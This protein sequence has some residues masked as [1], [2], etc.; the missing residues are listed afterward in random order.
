MVEIT[1]PPG[2]QPPSP[3]SATSASGANP[4]STIQT[5]QPH[6]EDMP[7]GSAP[8]DTAWRRWTLLAASLSAA[9]VVVLCGWTLLSSAERSTDT[10]LSLVAEEV[11]DGEVPD[12]PPKQDSPE[13]AAAEPAPSQPKQRPPRKRHCLRLL[14]R[15]TPSRRI[16]S[17]RRNPSRISRRQP[18]PTRL[19]FP[20]NNRRPFSNRR[21]RRQLRPQDYHPPKCCRCPTGEAAPQARRADRVDSIR[22]GQAV[23]P[24][25]VLVRRSDRD[26]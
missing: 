21:R 25:A 16:R 1:P 9:V 7:A 13:V 23:G 18:R 26:H 5:P 3:P 8:P 22:R 20:Q 2:W 15:R 6:T 14:C 12:E 10:A 4:S 24:R 19:P 11:P 17:S